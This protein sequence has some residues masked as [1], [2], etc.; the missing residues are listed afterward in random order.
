[1]N[2]H[3]AKTF[4]KISII[5][6][7]WSIF[8][9]KFERQGHEL[10]H[11]YLLGASPTLQIVSY[12]LFVGKNDNTSLVLRQSNLG[13]EGILLGYCSLSCIL[14]FIFITRYGDMVPQ[15]LRGKL[16]GS[17]CS[18]VGVLLLALPVPIIEEKVRRSWS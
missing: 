17:C 9:I 10:S 12:T 3:E 18:L 16:I 2:D 5:Y 15:T 13:Y 11:I 14:V 1:M 8:L 6:L 4:F 7:I